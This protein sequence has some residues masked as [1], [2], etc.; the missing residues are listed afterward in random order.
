MD[1]GFARNLPVAIAW[2]FFVASLFSDLFLPQLVQSAGNKIL[3][4]GI[5]FGILISAIILS[6]KFLHRD[7][8]LIE[9]QYADINKK[10]SDSVSKEAAIINN[11]VD[12]IG[13]IDTHSCFVSVN[14]AALNVL[15]Y[16]PDEIIGKP[17]S[18]FILPEDVDSSLSAT[19]G[20]NKSIDR[21]IF[22]NRWRRKDGKII[23]LLWSAH[24]SAS[25]NGLFCVIH[26][27]TERKL[28]E[29]AV[30]ESE[31]RIRLILESLPIALFICN[32]VGLIELCN[33]TG[34]SLTS[35]DRAELFAKSLQVLVPDLIKTGSMI[36]FEDLASSLATT[37]HESTIR[38]KNGESL[39]VEISMRE[40]QLRGEKKYIF[41]A[42][43]ITERYELDKAKREFVAMVSHDL[44]SPLNS[45]LIT[46][47]ILDDGKLG[48]LNQKGKQFVSQAVSESKRLIELIKDLLDLEKIGSSNFTLH[49]ERV[50]MLEVIHA[51][52]NAVKSS[53]ER[54]QLQF[55]IPTEDIECDADGA[56]LIQVLINLLSNAVKFAPSGSQITVQLEKEENNAKVTVLDNGRGIPREKQ[57]RIFEKF[58]QVEKED[59]RQ[60]GGSGLGLAICKAIVEEHSGQIGVASEEGS[61]TRFW[62]TIPLN[63]KL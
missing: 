6:K 61:Q 23:H 4:H 3:L 42:L 13:L 46:L 24:W 45:I 19:L 43:D 32:R 44:R 25:D 28:A 12:V 30:Q 35:Y 58:A 17:I 36:E 47:N 53:A 52:I 26:D 31:E 49:F 5:Q 22:E 41:A 33:T 16:T 21:I 14:P 37:G 2:F 18:E 63:A 9:Q 55:Q 1:S 15:S 56:R 51:S 20:A 59:W 29:Q 34:E 10:L 8:S 62:F 54:R 60:K 7:S 50:S 40:I 11:A 38:K 48:E 39:A 57:D 27:I